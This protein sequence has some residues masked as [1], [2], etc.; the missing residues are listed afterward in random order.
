[1][2]NQSCVSS[3]GFDF[4]LRLT[5]RRCFGLRENVGQQDIMMLTE[6]IERLRKRD[7]VAGDQPRSLMNQLV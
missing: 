3:R 6:G 2:R 5:K 4:L 1:M 7:K